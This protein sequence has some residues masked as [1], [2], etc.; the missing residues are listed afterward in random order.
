[1]LALRYYPSYFYNSLSLQAAASR[2]V[3]RLSV[4]ADS[5]TFVGLHQRDARL[6]GEGYTYSY[7]R[8]CLAR[9]RGGELEC[10]RMELQSKRNIVF[11]QL[12]QAGEYVLLVEPVWGASGPVEFTLSTYSSAFAFLSELQSVSPAQYGRM[13]LLA[14]RSYCEANPAALV[15]KHSSTIVDAEF[16]M[17]AKQQGARRRGPR[18]Q[19]VLHAQLQRRARRAPVI[20]AEL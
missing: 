17:C 2:R 19:R 8:V 12:L 3:V 10:V 18:R 16:A 7:F 4:D 14:W 11:E 5:H 9:V 1:M 15:H 20:R 13:E 6:L